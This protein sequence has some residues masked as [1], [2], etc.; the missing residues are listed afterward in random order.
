MYTIT[1]KLFDEMG[2]GHDEYILYLRDEN[3]VETQGIIYVGKFYEDMYS[4]VV[5]K[6]R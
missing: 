5:V 4:T 3:R 6:D 1:C 2:D